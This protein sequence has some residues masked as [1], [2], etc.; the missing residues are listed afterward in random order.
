[1]KKRLL[2]ACIILVLSAAAAVALW[3]FL[4]PQYQKETVMEEGV[5]ITKR[6]PHEEEPEEPQPPAL[7][8]LIADLRE[9]YN[10][11]HIVGFIQIPNTNIYYPVLQYV[12]NAFYLYHD[13]HGVRTAA[14]SIFLDYENNL[15]KLDDDNTIIYGHNMIAGNKFHNI[16]YFH[17]EEFF[18]NHTYI[19]LHTPYQETVWDVFSFF[20]TTIY[21]NYLTTNFADRDRFYD[22]LLD[23]QKRSHFETSIELERDD[24]ILI[25]S[26]C[27]VW[28]GIHRYVVAARLRNE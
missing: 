24:Q 10:N 1:M 3:C 16:R 19:I 17:N 25:L 28:G 12:D 14:G 8:P 15:Y 22:F 23:L 21:F 2:W 13:R 27:G 11:D 26:T 9:R 20:S 18:R 7:L 4:I 6:E 5:K